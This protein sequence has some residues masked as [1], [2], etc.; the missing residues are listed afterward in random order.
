MKI[1]KLISAYLDGELSRDEDKELRKLIN[2]DP[3]TK[4]SFDSYVD[5]HIA[6]KED[7]DNIQP[8]EDLVRDTED[9]VMMKIL[10]KAN[11]TEVV[12]S[13]KNRPVYTYLAAASVIILLGFVFRINDSGII[14]RY[15]NSDV[16]TISN[17]SI[18]NL[19]PETFDVSVPKG[20]VFANQSKI[21][22]NE[23]KI[24]LNEKSAKSAE[25]IQLSENFATSVNNSYSVNEDLSMLNNYEEPVA[26]EPNRINSFVTKDRNLLSVLITMPDSDNIREN[27][28]VTQSTA[29]PDDINIPIYINSQNR[30]RLTSFVSNGLV[31]SGLNNKNNKSVTN[32]SQS[33]SYHSSKKVSY[34]L[35]IG[36]L[37]FTSDNNLVQTQGGGNS[38]VVASSVEVLNPSNE[39]K[40]VPTLLPVKIDNQLFWGSVFVNY[41]ILN[42]NRLSLEGRLGVGGTSH[43][44]LG[45]GRL[46]TKIKLLDGIYL[47]AGT[48]GKLFIYNYNGN[49]VTGSDLSFIYGLQFA[50]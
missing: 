32:Y 10:N 37:E 16:E 26:D 5:M 6:I 45:Y 31:S 2:E 18:D 12:K 34:G 25:Q 36:Y 22:S 24:I 35:E 11:N 28:F 7:S 30:I 41:N 39:G 17:Y 29:F 40:F 8:P 13:K 14:N 20:S 42:L 15:F 48:E 47:S 3:D 44:P 23:A 21:E 1:E 33:I 50:F 38:S 49:D 9:L 46:F 4:S 19:N 27:S 43:G